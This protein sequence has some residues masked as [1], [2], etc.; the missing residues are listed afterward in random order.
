VPSLKR[1][2][3]RGIWARPW[4]LALRAG[5][6][7]NPVIAR[8][9]ARAIPNH[10]VFGTAIIVALLCRPETVSLYPSRR[11]TQGWT[12][13]WKQAP[14]LL[15]AREREDWEDTEAD[16]AL[17]GERLRKLATEESSP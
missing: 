12:A 10:A 14:E 7:R 1:Y 15:P 16:L 17:I 8:S 9:I 2:V 6:N 3:A 11:V 5:E 4:Q 13:L